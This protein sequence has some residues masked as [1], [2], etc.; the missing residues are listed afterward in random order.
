MPDHYQTLQAIRQIS[1]K[2]LSSITEPN[3]HKDVGYRGEILHISRKNQSSITEPNA[4]KDVGY[5]GEILH[6][7]RIRNNKENAGRSNL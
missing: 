3:A 4:H 6:H 2:N 5:R 1:R 7:I